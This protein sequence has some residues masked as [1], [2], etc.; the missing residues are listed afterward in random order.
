MKKQINLK[1]F[2]YLLYSDENVLDIVSKL[3]ALTGN[4]KN[5]GFVKISLVNIDS[6]LYYTELVKANQF[7]QNDSN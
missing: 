2:V 1:T 4:Q 5:C 6:F 7:I 3:H